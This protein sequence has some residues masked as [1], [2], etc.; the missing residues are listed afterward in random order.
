MG[1]CCTRVLLTPGVPVCG[2]VF[3]GEHFKNLPKVEIDCY[4]YTQLRTNKIRMRAINLYL[5]CFWQRCQQS[6]KK[7]H[8]IMSKNMRTK[9]P[10]ELERVCCWK[11]GFKPLH[12]AS[13]SAV[14]TAQNSLALTLVQQQVAGVGVMLHNTENRNS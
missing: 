2:P 1:G 10:S 7:M 3:F 6:V 12:F 9:Q 5:H 11:T 14:L 8:F 13:R 4:F